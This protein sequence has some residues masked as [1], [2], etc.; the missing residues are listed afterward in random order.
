MTVTALL[1]GTTSELWLPLSQAEEEEHGSLSD[2]AQP[3]YK[4]SHRK[5]PKRFQKKRVASAA[6]S[7][8]AG[9]DKGIAGDDKGIAADD[10]G[11]AGEKGV[12]G[13]DKGIAGHDKGIAGH[14]KGIAGDDTGIAGDI[15]AF[16]ESDKGIADKT[17]AASK[18]SGALTKKH[19]SAAGDIL[20]LLP[21]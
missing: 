15:R 3:A 13:H 14:N 8:S 7:K 1:L 9:D 12:A 21:N 5:Q 20:W 6:A 4:R 16:A 18:Q 19:A 10:K 11:I 2:K 17:A